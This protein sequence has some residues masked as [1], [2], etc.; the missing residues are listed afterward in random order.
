MPPN[1]QNLLEV[2]DWNDTI[3]TSPGVCTSTGTAPLYHSSDMYLLYW[4]PS[5]HSASINPGPHKVM[6]KPLASS[7]TVTCRS[8]G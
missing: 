6:E 3:Q 8:Q 1:Q 7:W 4:C 2:L 5:C